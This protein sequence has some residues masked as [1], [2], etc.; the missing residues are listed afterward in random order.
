VNDDELRRVLE[1][2]GRQ[3]APEPRP[4][5]VRDLEARLTAMRVV[6]SP[7]RRPW[8]AI[9]AAAA[10]LVVVI[11]GLVALVRDDPEQQVTT[12][13][14][15]STTTVATTTVPSTTVTTTAAPTTTTSV[16]VPTTTT[17]LEPTT[18]VVTGPSTTTTSA[19]PRENLR[20]ACVTSQ[21]PRPRVVCEW[22]AS[23]SERVDHYRLWKHTGDGPD[24]EV[25]AGDGQRAE[26][27]DVRVGANLVYEVTAITADGTVISHGDARV[28]CC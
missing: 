6:S 22:S 21:D 15:R 9:G 26:D 10:A 24:V 14:A 7:A 8:R 5:L 27:T 13:P 16:P 23:T 28:T 1:A 3:D 4:D 11:G 20:L 19:P 25:Y 17:T 2:A 18:T 12:E